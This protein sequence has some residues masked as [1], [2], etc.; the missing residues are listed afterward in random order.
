MIRHRHAADQLLQ[1]HD[2]GGGEEGLDRR[3]KVA[4]GAFQN[5]DF[6]VAA[7]IAHLDHEHEAVQLR[8]GEGVSALLL[9]GILG[10][11]HEERIRKIVGAA[12]AGGA[13][14]LHGFQQGGLGLGRGAVD[15]VR[16][17]EIGEDGSADEFQLA[18]AGLGILLN[19]VR[20]GDV[21]G[22]EVGRELDAAEGKV[23]GRGEGLNHDGFGEAGHTFE[24][25]MTAAEDRVDQLFEHLVLA[26]DD[27]MELRQQVGAGGGQLRHEGGFIPGFGLPRGGLGHG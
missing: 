19:D 20:A 17:Q 7:G 18:P 25:A 26:D 23:Q 3:G 14:L 4:G 1:L 12:A 10:G 8:F 9:D 5:F 21:G 22:H 15:F 11:E 16:Q 2:F 13:A 27:L 24:Q 6:L